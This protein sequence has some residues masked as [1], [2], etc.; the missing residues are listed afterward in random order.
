MAIDYKSNIDTLEKSQLSNYVNYDGADFN[1]IMASS[2]YAGLLNKYNTDLK[3]MQ[4]ADANDQSALQNMANW[5]ET[6]KTSMIVC[7]PCTREK[8]KDDKNQDTSYTYC[9][10]IGKYEIVVTAPNGRPIKISGST[11]E[12]DE[13]FFTIGTKTIEMGDE[14]KMT[15]TYISLDPA[16][17]IKNIMVTDNNGSSTTLESFIK[18]TNQKIASLERS[19]QTLTSNYNDLHNKLKK[20]IFISPTTKQNNTY[21]WFGTAS[22]YAA[23]GTNKAAGTSYIVNR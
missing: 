3:A 18:S 2:D 9:Q 5:T 20:A 23:I 13:N 6:L 10:D 14:S 12:I 21:M 15:T 11:P 7:A 22:Q 19:I 4:S 16:K 8:M 17:V 1:I